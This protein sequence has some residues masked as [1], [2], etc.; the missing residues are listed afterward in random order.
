MD[1]EPEWQEAPQEADEEEPGYS[2]IAIKNFWTNMMPKIYCNN[3]VAKIDKELIQNVT[4]L[5]EILKLK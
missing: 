5:Q 1:D 2:R 4:D 3:F